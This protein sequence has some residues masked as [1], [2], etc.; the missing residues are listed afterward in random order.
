MVASE[1]V[2]STHFSFPYTHAFLRNIK[3]RL[4]RNVKTRNKRQSFFGTAHDNSARAHPM[5]A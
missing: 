1:E 2:V 5:E 4:A 3:T